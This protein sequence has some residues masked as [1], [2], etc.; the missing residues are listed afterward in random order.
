MNTKKLQKGFTLAESVIAITLIIIGIVGILNL[1]NRSAGFANIASNRLIAANLGQEGIEIVRNIRDSN[2][3][4][5]ENWKDG[6]VGFCD[7]IFQLDYNQGLK[8]NT[9]SF[10]LFDEELGYN[11]QEGKETIYKRRLEIAEITNAELRVK[12]IV[13]WQTRGGDFEIVVEDHLY[14]WF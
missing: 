3:V 9:N 11:H 4:N 12:A 13:S 8:C 10:L 6:L 14:N 1:I 2:W 5:Q 7:G